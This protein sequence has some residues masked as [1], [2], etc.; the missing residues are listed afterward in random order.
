VARGCQSQE[1]QVSG[2]SADGIRARAVS[3]KAEP[4]KE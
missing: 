3:K 1:S 4:D 2:A